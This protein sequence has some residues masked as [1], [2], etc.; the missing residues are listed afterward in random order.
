MRPQTAV[1][2]ELYWSYC[3]HRMYHQPHY[4]H[5]SN[6]FT[7]YLEEVYIVHVGR[8]EKVVEMPAADFWKCNSLV[9]KLIVML[10]L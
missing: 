7:M 3:D 2:H 6:V 9:G 4:V 5:T 10:Q 8:E 1:S